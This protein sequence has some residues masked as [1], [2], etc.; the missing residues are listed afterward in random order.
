MY[1]GFVDENRRERNPLIRLQ[2]KRGRQ[3]DVSRLVASS[4]RVLVAHEGAWSPYSHGGFWSEVTDILG[5][6]DWVNEDPGNPQ[7]PVSVVSLQ[8]RDKTPFCL[9]PYIVPL[10]FRVSF[11]ISASR[12]GSHTL[13]SQVY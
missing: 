4:W 2:M 8:T 10:E 5:I 11:R 9:L 3:Y 12:S 13:K 1:L 6:E 7:S